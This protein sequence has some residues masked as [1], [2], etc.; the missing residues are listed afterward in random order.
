MNRNNLLKGLFIGIL[1]VVLLESSASSDPAAKPAGGNPPKEAA[2]ASDSE[3]D[4]SQTLDRLRDLAGTTTSSHVEKIKSFK[5]HRIEVGDR[6]LI[7]IYPEDEFIKGSEMEVSSEG[8]ITL[9]LIGKVKV[10]G[11]QIAEV[12]KEIVRLLAEDYLVN[13]VVVVEVVQRIED[14]TKEKESV[15]V[16][17]SVQKPG[18]YDFPAEGKFTLLKLISAAGG[19]SDVANVKKIK[20]I[21]KENGRPRILHANAEAIISGNEPDV[22]LEPEDVVNVGESFF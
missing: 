19:F 2:A 8:T 21:R 11:M 20:V 15:S 10:E 3:K 17:G 6:V 4:S 22:E 1:F 16:L 18:S 7:K 5:A 12:E 13:P 9:P 14:K